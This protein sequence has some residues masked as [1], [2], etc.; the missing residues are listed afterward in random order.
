MQPHATLTTQVRR[1]IATGLDADSARWL[2][3]Y[4]YSVQDFRIQAA[5][6]LRAV[7]QETDAGVASLSEH[8]K[9]NMATTE[10]EIQK[11]LGEYA[12]ASPPGQWAL[13]QVGIGPVIAAGMLAHIDIR[14]APTVGHIWRFAGLDDPANYE[15]GKKQKRPWNAK[16]KVLCWKTGDSFVK[17]SGRETAFYGHVYRE[18]KALEVERNDRG[19]FNALAVR[20]LAERD[21]KDADL[22]KCYESGRLPDGRIDLRARRV[23]VK[24]FLSHL[25]HVMYVDFYGEQ[26]PKPY[27]LTIEGGHAHFIPPPNWP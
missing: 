2:V 8:L 11:A 1:D 14:K 9:N 12:A 23:A 24:L 15:W 22:R 21:I 18:R 5:N 4:Y 10:A 6:Q 17:Q 25:H 13:S 3:D 20:A 16:L 19:D 7:V 26:P 27:I